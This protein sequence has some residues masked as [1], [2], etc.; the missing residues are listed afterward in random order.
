MKYLR[1]YLY[2]HFS[3]VTLTRRLSLDRYHSPWVGTAATSAEHTGYS[4]INCNR[5][6]SGF[7]V[8]PFPLT[9]SIIYGKS[10][11]L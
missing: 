5:S 10:A 9:R 1:V 11:T 4:D 6:C 3:V 7:C 2:S 8:L